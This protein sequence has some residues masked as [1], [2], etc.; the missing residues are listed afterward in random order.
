MNGD[1]DGGAWLPIFDSATTPAELAVII[2]QQVQIAMR[3]VREQINAWPSVSARERI[4]AFAL[5][6]PI[7]RARTTAQLTSAWQRLQGEAASGSAW[8]H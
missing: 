4:A 3:A 1:D 2:D 5:A 7:V 6:E 8:I